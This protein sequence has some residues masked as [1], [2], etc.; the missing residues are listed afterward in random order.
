MLSRRVVRALVPAVALALVLAA[1]G[2]DDSASGDT[3][4]TAPATEPEETTTTTEP[5]EGG[6]T[7]ATTDPTE[8]EPDP[9]PG[10][11]EE[12]VALAESVILVESDFVEGWTSEEPSDSEEGIDACFR[13]VS[14]DDDALADVP[15]LVFSQEDAEAQAFISVS[16]TGIVFA[17]A[18]AASTVIQE[19]GT[20]AFAGCALDQ[21]LDEFSGDSGFTLDDAD[22]SPGG[23]GGVGEESAILN[24]FFSLTSPDLTFDGE[25]SIWF[26]RTGEVVSGFA[27][28]SFGDTEFALVVDQVA[29][30]IDDRHAALA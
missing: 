3:T 2:G 26:V 15:S 14:V 11:D 21:M 24:G 28:I 29:G 30:V 19:A 13:D 10:G 23:D 18:E 12:A 6:L 5:E 9:E 25:L 7:G 16:S 22:I 20:N 8:P 4:T 27:V 17:D 1:C